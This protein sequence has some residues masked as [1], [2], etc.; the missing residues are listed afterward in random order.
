MPDTQTLVLVAAAM[1]AGVICFRLY[2]VL[3]R[4]TGNETPPQPAPSALTPPPSQALPEA[5]PA[6]NGLLDIQLAD[7]G[8]DTPKFLAGAREAYGRIVTAFAQGDRDTLRP[9]LSPDVYAAF[10]AGI[11][12]RG[13]PAADFVKLADAR[14]A[15]SAL[16]GR[17][18]E[19]TVAFTA[20][21]STGT[22][23]DV[24]TFERSLDS[25]D[26]NWLLVATSGDLPDQVDGG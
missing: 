21:F 4:R 5:V 12:G 17:V 9:L 13:A 15:H 25:V 3:G 14:I 2:T 19:I 7:R 6:S 26:P 11:T 24:W 8:F 23:T 10:D 16:Q 1:A 20:E 18:A 22:V